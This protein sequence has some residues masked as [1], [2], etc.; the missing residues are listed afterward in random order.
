MHVGFIANVVEPLFLE[1]NRFLG[2]ALTE[3]Q[4]GNLRL[5][6]SKWEDVVTQ[7]KLQ[8]QTVTV[9]A[10][11][12]NVTSAPVE[13][14][15]GVRDIVVV[16]LS[17]SNLNDL[18]D[19]KENANPVLN[20]SN[21]VDILTRQFGRNGHRRHSLPT[22]RTSDEPVPS[23]YR[24][25]TQSRR[26]SLPDCERSGENCPSLSTARRLS[27][28]VE[29][30]PVGDDHFDYDDNSNLHCVSCETNS[31]NC[32]LKIE[33]PELFGAGRRRS[34]IVQTGRL[35]PE[36]LDANRRRASCPLNVVNRISCVTSSGKNSSSRETGCPLQQQQQPYS[37]A[38]PP[39]RLPLSNRRVT[40]CGGTLRKFSLTSF[41]DAHRTAANANRKRSR[42]LVTST[43]LYPIDEN[44]RRLRSLIA[45]AACD[46][47]FWLQPEK[48]VGGLGHDSL[49]EG[50]RAD[51]HINHFIT[52]IKLPKP[53][54]LSVVTNTRCQTENSSGRKRDD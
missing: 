10:C 46:S 17:I 14:H 1:W 39:C 33:N 2:S 32:S 34:E 22:D 29:C 23:A 19:D 50:C 40:E 43:L 31:E 7:E 3:L 4:L 11:A 20:D 52:S 42:S 54:V 15:R 30:S 28:L 45:N 18:A 8:A 53:P 16:D 49:L 13:V 36:D 25:V 38:T 6:R 35:V 44:L 24:G 12:E 47:L 9:I 41:D 5:N 51:D 48:S 21:L 37:V 27:S 26:H